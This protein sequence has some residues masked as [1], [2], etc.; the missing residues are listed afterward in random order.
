MWSIAQKT[1]DWVKNGLISSDQAQHIVLFEKNKK[2]LFSFYSVMLLLG[3]FSI[4]CGIVAVISSNWENISGAVKVV[5]LFISLITVCLFLLT[6]NEKRPVVFQTVLSFYILLLFAAIGLVAQVYHL[7]SETYKAFLFWSILSFPLLCLSRKKFWGYVWEPIFAFSLLSSP[8]GREVVDFL[9]HHCIPFP[10]YAS[11]L[12]VML[13]F[14]VLR[15]KKIPFLTQPLRDILFMAALMGLVTYID[16]YTIQNKSFLGGGAIAFYILSL[17]ST[18]FLYQSKAFN[19]NEKKIVYGIILSYLLY[20]IFMSS[21][22][23]NYFFQLFILINFIFTA[24]FFN[25]EKVAR[26]LAVFTVARILFAF[27]SLFGSLIYTGIG[28]IVSG[29]VILVMAVVCVKIDAF[30]KRKIK[31]SEAYDE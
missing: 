7:K 8:Y 2:S 15:S 16:V 1:D 4:A 12:S 14:A 17:V 21:R 19:K 23:V 22:P 18:F 30:L 13:F 3:V 29:C 26:L 6:I 31:K 5:G 9:V 10:L 28:M 27:F 25:A 20:F 11:F 24:Y